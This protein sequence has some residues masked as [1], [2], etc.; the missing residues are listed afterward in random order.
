LSKHRKTNPDL[1]FSQLALN[2]R[3]LSAFSDGTVIANWRRRRPDRLKPILR[4]MQS[5]IVESSVYYPDTWEKGNWKFI[6]EYWS[7]RYNYLV[8]KRFM[9]VLTS[10]VVLLLVFPWLFPIIV[11]LIKLDSR[12]PVFFRQ[13][14]IGFLGKTF[15]CYKFRTMYVNEYADTRRA[16][17]NDPRVTRVGWFLRNTC[18]D[19]LPQ[20]INVL[21]GQM[22]IVGPR[23]HMLKDAQEFSNLVSNYSFR[24]L[25]RP[26]IT[27]LSQVRGY[28]GP[29]TSFESILRRYQWDSYYVRNLSFVLDLKI[30]FNTGWLIVKSFIFRDQPV[31]A[32][33]KVFPN[34]EQLAA[35]KKIA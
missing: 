10:T 1:C 18:L 11:L 7:D 33:H 32:D 26:G 8:Y 14:R 9:D 16:A 13:K 24:N 25:A 31:P 3:L 5:T 30:M 2:H 15:W 12:G 28:R 6:R 35:V 17:C 23:P 21:L 34:Q 22:S 19:E 27:G 29:A 20:F 4:N